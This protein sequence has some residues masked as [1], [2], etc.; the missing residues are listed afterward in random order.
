[1]KPNSKFIHS[2]SSGQN[3]KF[4][5]GFTLVELLASIIVLVAVGSVI[6]GIITASLRGTNKTTTIENIRQNGNYAIA[7]VSRTI[8]YAQVFNGFS[9]DGTTYIITCPFL[10]SPTPPA[11]VTTKY[12]F[13][14]VTQLNNDPIVYNCTSSSPFTIT[15]NGASL[16][17]TD[18]LAL[19]ECVL[20]CIQSRATDVPVIKV[21]FKLGPKNSNSLVESSTPPILFETS[22]IIRNYRK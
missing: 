22:V 21:S 8:E 9:N 3:S 18:S 1:M 2:A 6:S 16:I 11:P 12:K 14:K 10:P 5:N 20:A 7:Q 17:D 15:A 13:L 4:S 19:T